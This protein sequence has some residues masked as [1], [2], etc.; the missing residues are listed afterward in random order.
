MKYNHSKR[1]LLGLLLIG[2]GVIFFLQQWGYISFDIGDLIRMFWPLILVYVGL[3][4]LLQGGF[5]GIIPL[6]IGA[7][8]LL[9]N[10]NIITLSWTEFMSYGVPLAL[11]GG[12][13]WVLFKPKHFKREKSDWESKRENGDQ[14]P[15]QTSGYAHSS[16]GSAPGN[17]PDYSDPNYPD[18][19]KDVDYSKDTKHRD[20]DESFQSMEHGTSS[21]FD[22]ESKDQASSKSWQFHMNMGSDYT[23]NKGKTINK[24]TFIGDF[25]LGQDYWELRPMNI[26]QFIGDTT[27][28]LT[29]AQVP[30]GETKINISS[31][32][33][34]VKVYVPRDVDLGIRVSTSSFIGDVHLL[35]QKESGFMRSVEVESPYYQESSRRVR[36]EVSTFIGDVKV[37]KVG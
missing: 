17:Y 30:Y 10:L 21:S 3:T 9:R 25:H 32:I 22:K 18:P 27:I 35:K 33:G 14:P 16:H 20:W 29:K 15:N 31:F 24:S 7:Y 13:L 37:K 4:G 1:W 8:Y 11:I 5:W 28:D 19:F 36:I 26:S 34:D 23:N 6:G 12:G 2:V